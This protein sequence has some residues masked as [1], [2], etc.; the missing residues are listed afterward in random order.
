[1]GRWLPFQGLKK[2][3]LSD[4]CCINAFINHSFYDIIGSVFVL[5]TKFQILNRKCSVQETYTGKKEHDRKFM[6]Y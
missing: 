3:I 6:F 5:S 4:K 1:M 2:T